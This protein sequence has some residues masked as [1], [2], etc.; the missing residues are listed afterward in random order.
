MTKFKCPQDNFAIFSYLTIM[1]KWKQIF[2]NRQGLYNNFKYI[3]LM[4]R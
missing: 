4:D 2:F 1:Q 3:L